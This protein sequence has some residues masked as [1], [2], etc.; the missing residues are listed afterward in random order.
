VDDFRGVSLQLIQSHFKG[1]G[2][3]GQVGRVE[4]LPVE[5]HRALHTEAIDQRLIDITL[6]SIPKAREFTNETLLDIL[7]YTSPV[8]CEVVLSSFL[9]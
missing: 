8:F 6:P 4:I 3:R 7:F 9:Y 5:W 2:E 1:A